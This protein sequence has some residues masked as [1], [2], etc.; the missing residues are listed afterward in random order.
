MFLFGGKTIYKNFFNDCQTYEM[1]SLA[2]YN[3][4]REFLID[5][6]CLVGSDYTDGIRGVGQ[7]MALE[8]LEHFDS[9][10]GFKQFCNDTK[11][12]KWEIMNE[13]KNTK[14]WVLIN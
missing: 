11:I 3:I 6:A 2:E 5:Y 10:G 7:I 12:L 1:S 4:D 13:S 9:L 8:I 14:K